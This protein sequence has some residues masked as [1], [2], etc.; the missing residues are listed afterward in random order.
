MLLTLWVEFG[1][2][3]MSGCGEELPL[4]AGWMSGVTTTD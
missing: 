2:E 1:V 4:A 3:E